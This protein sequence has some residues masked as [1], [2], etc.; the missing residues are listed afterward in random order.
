MS[1]FTNLNKTTLTD[2]VNEIPAEYMTA[3]AITVTPETTNKDL[4]AILEEYEATK[5]SD[6]T[7]GSDTT[8]N[9][10]PSVQKVAVK[11]IE[12]AELEDGQVFAGVTVYGDQSGISEELA[13]YPKVTVMIPLMEGEPKNSTQFVCLNGANFH[14]TKGKMVSIPQPLAQI[15]EN[16]FHLD[17]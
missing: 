7:A 15:I 8:T 13:K 17:I 6:N 3:N 10:T 2:L 1:K 9:E 14:I 12:R 11:R 4:V 5:P 16:S